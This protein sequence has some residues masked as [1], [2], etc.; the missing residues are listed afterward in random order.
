MAIEKENQEQIEEEVKVDTP[1]EQPEGLPPDVMV[2][3]QEPVVENLEEEFSANL[4]DNMDERI[5]KSLGSELLSEYKK[6]KTSRKDWED[7]YIKG[8]DLLGTNYTE[9]SKPFKGASGVTHPLLAESVTQFQASAYKELLPSDGPVRTSIVGLRTK[10]ISMN[11]YKDHVLS[12]Y[13][14]KI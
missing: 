4:A 9:Q 1:Q 2:E 10:Y 14:Q 5:L 13:L 8:L 7:A 3:G 6:D 11:F 12:L